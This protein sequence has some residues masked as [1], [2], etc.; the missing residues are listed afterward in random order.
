[1]DTISFVNVSTLRVS[2]Q[3]VGSARAGAHKLAHHAVRIGLPK[4]K[5]VAMQAAY[6]TGPALALETNVRTARIMRRNEES[7]SAIFFRVTT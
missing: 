2:L 4:L 3:S 1:M 6:A 7:V 5:Q